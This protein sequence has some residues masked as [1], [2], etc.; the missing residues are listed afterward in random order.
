MEISDI[1]SGLIVT[2]CG[3][4]IWVNSRQEAKRNPGNLFSIGIALPLGVVITA[5]GLL[6]LWSI[7]FG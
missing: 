1:L 6:R 7:I 2:A 5:L 3:I 4:V